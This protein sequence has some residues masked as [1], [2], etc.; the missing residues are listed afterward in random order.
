MALNSSTVEN[1]AND[2][3][4][5]LHG[6]Q[7]PQD[8]RG[9]CCQDWR[10]SLT[11][12][13]VRTSDGQQIHQPR[14]SQYPLDTAVTDG[15][16][17][18]AFNYAIIPLSSFTS[19]PE[20]VRP[21]NYEDCINSVNPLYLHHHNSQV[22]F[23]RAFDLKDE[24]SDCVQIFSPPPP[25][26]EIGYD[27][28][29]QSVT[30]ATYSTGAA[31]YHNPPQYE[32][33]SPGS[34]IGTTQE[35]DVYEQAE[36]SCERAETVQSAT[37]GRSIVSRPTRD[38]SERFAS[39]QT[40]QPLTSVSLVQP[41]ALSEPVSSAMSINERDTNIPASESIVKPVSTAPAIGN[42]KNES[43]P[44]I[45]TATTVPVELL[46]RS[47]LIPSQPTNTILWNGGHQNEA[48]LNET[49]ATPGS[50]VG[51]TITESCNVHTDDCCQMG[52][53]IESEQNKISS[54]FSGSHNK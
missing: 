24:R 41:A 27:T 8:G 47:G 29:M 25:Y 20:A 11:C 53:N 3:H 36:Y 43:V 16:D 44:R 39:L 21:P 31:T 32:I 22:F 33:M 5:Q 18:R 9:N 17:I 50:F 38:T 30:G 1:G 40:C 49:F 15:E 46:R 34:P 13:S 51:P 6:Q 35:T 2:R 19:D 4:Q 28:P 10:G 7:P 45:N 37:Q 23:N 26:S 52:N 14:I 42:P 48:S 54:N 12:A